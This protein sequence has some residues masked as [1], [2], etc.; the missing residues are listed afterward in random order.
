MAIWVRATRVGGRGSAACDQ[1]ATWVRAT[2][3]GGRGGCVARWRCCESRK[4]SGFVKKRCGRRR[5]P[6][7]RH[8]TQRV[9]LSS[10]SFRFLLVVLFFPPFFFAFPPPYHTKIQHTR[11][12]VHGNARDA[13]VRACGHPRKHASVFCFRSVS[14]LEICLIRRNMSSTLLTS[15]WRVHGDVRSKMFYEIWGGHINMQ[16]TCY[17]AK[18]TRPLVYLSYLF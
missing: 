8:A 16:G 4:V 12:H 2:R 11:A 7:T 13:L 15:P 5:A 3:V 17:F 14:C 1:M 18:L 6:H 10:P 9:S